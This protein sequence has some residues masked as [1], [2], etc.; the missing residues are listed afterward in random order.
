[1]VPRTR[2][3]VSNTSLEQFTEQGFLVLPDFLSAE[4]VA[5]LNKGVDDS[6]TGRPEDWWRLSDSFRQAPNVLPRTDLFDFTIEQRP[7]LDLVENWFGENISFEEFSIL[8]RDPTENLNE[9]K[10]WHRDIT[11]D[12]SR[13]EE[14]DAVSL[15]YLLTDVEE[16]DHCFSIVPRSHDRLLHLRPNEHKPGDEVDILGAAGTAILFHARCLHCGKLKLKGRQR[17]SLHIYYSRA[18]GPRT[19]EWTDIPKRLYA[20]TD[21]SLPV[22]LYSKWNATD[23]FDGTGKKPR[24]LPAGLSMA[25]MLREVQRRARETAANTERKR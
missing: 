3:I 16:D 25:E 18:G 6:L 10:G 2:W 21:P 13:R 15:I 7:I 1:M 12:Y 14:I 9:A 4:Q 19:S 23:V 5:G 24:N 11:R 8:I 20:K 17:R 22:Q